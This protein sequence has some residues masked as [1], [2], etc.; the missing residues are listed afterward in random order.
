MSRER[1]R[2]DLHFAQEARSSGRALPSESRSGLVSFLSRCFRAK[3]TSTRII[4]EL[5]EKEEQQRVR[6]GGKR[7]QP[8]RIV[9]RNKR[10]SG[11][12]GFAV[13]RASLPNW[14]TGDSSVLLIKAYRAFS[15]GRDREQKKEDKRVREERILSLALCSYFSR[16]LDFC[17]VANSLSCPGREPF[18][19]GRTI[20]IIKLYFTTRHAKAES[21]QRRWRICDSADLIYS[22]IRRD[23]HFHKAS[24]TDAKQFPQFT[25][26]SPLEC[27]VLLVRPKPS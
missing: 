21:S 1:N 14:I 4:L 24:R 9:P 16:T 25:P 2:N 8:P 26:R 6:E 20:L 10:E 15:V 11:K 13:I 19:S 12:G 18:C 22:A 3:Q 17:H 23:W 27:E 7:L 5:A